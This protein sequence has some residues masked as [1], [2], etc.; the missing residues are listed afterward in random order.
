MIG[1]ELLGRPGS[2][3]AVDH[4]HPDIRVKAEGPDL[5][6]QVAASKL[7]LAP[8]RLFIRGGGDRFVRRQGVT[9]LAV[10]SR[11]GKVQGPATPAA[12]RERHRELKSGIGRL[13]RGDLFLAKIAAK[14]LSAVRADRTV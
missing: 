1:Q 10:G 8:E 9:G 13:L 11:R 2:S 5:A 12:V 4:G 6:D 3:E 7:E 14:G